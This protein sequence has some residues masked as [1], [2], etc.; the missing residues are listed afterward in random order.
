MKNLIPMNITLNDPDERRASSNP[1][2][3]EVHEKAA[4]RSIEHKRDENA[5]S[6]PVGD[7]SPALFTER[8]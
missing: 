5:Q 8:L 3:I 6:N 4:R 7:A 1:N 2:V